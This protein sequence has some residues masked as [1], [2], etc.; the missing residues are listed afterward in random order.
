MSM[1]EGLKLSQTSVFRLP[2]LFWNHGPIYASSP[3]LKWC[4]TAG[5]LLFQ[6]ISPVI[7][8][9]RP[10]F[11]FP[12]IASIFSFKACLWCLFFSSYF[13]CLCYLTLARIFSFKTCLWSMFF[14]SY[15]DCV[16]WHFFFFFSFKA[17]LWSLFFFLLLFWL[18]VLLDISKYFQFQNL[19]VKHVF[20]FL[21]WLCYLTFYF[22][23]E[24]LFVKLV[25]F[26][27][28]L[29]WLFVLLDISKYFQFQNL[30]VKHAFF[31]L[32]L[33]VCVTWQKP[34]FSVSKLCFQG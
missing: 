14:P 18:F 1:P 29:F 27:L 34:V 9:N 33:I 31:G 6:M 3:C 4:P 25:F 19:F 17:C 10:V 16:T 21:F 30:F 28:L 20:S 15:F 8:R 26:F 12:Y 13:D 5:A 2:P 24:S 11:V 7:S 22:Q 32:I 23:F